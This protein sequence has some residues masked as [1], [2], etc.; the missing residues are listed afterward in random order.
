[1]QLITLTP[2]AG[3]VLHPL[4]A[5]FPA[6][7]DTPLIITA[8]DAVTT[9]IQ[10]PLILCDGML[11]DGWER[12]RGALAGKLEIV[13]TISITEDEAAEV[14]AAMLLQRAHHG[15]SLRAWLVRHVAQ[16]VREE[17]N[18]RRTANL[19]RGAARHQ[20]IP[21]GV[22]TLE[23]LDAKYRLPH[24]MLARAVAIETK[25]QQRP[26]LRERWQPK[27]ESEE[28]TLGQVQ[29]GMAGR[30]S[31]EALKTPKGDPKQMMLALFSAAPVRLGRWEML[32][33]A[34]KDEVEEEYVSDMLAHLPERLLKRTERFLRERKAAAAMA[35]A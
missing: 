19:K 35:S 17:S 24:G 14:Y 29:Q 20:A 30:M 32:T 9:G 6:R 31:A 13:P 33:P 8:E 4:R 26:D 3:L 5:A 2:I 1:M 27:I 7:K 15:A 28:M 16:R 21:A 34:Q 10:L 22:E 25:F 18:V 12:L 11:L 23:T